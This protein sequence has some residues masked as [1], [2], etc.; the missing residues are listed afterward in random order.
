MSTSVLG[1]KGGKNK[2]DGGRVEGKQNIESLPYQSCPQFNTTI[3]GIGCSLSAKIKT[4][5]W[6]SCGE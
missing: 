3:W 6:Q 1:H 5:T 4:P 2:G